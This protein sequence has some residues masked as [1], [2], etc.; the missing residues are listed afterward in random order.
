[1]ILR[2]HLF[3]LIGPWHRSGN[4]VCRCYKMGVV[5]RKGVYN[6]YFSRGGVCAANWISR[7]KAPSK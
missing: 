2:G 4:L 3:N 5:Q 7:R 1:M 6:R